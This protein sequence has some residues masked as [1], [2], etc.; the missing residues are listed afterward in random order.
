M[1]TI[2]SAT[3]SAIYGLYDLDVIDQRIISMLQQDGRESYAKMGDE[4]GIPASTIR[5]RTNQMVTRGVIKV[6][7]VLNP[8]LQKRQIQAT[9]GV[10]VAEG[11]ARSL[12]EALGAMDEVTRLVICAGSFDLLLDVTCKDN[13]HLLDVLAKLRVMPHVRRAETFMHFSMPKGGPAVE[14]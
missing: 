12:A 1:M 11:D 4:M 9:V 7:A 14:F 2:Q 8:L 3:K 13:D 6:V 10:S 5:D